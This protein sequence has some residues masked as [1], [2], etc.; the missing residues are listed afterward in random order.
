MNLRERQKRGEHMQQ[1][2]LWRAGQH[3]VGRCGRDD[4]RRVGERAGRRRAC[5]A[6]AI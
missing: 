4:L 1:F 3:V 5:E 2:W 6:D